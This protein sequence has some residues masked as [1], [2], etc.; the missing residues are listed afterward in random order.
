[1]WLLKAPSGQVG[2]VL[3][4]SLSVQVGSSG[5]REVHQLSFPASPLSLATAAPLGRSCVS[6]S[7]AE[8]CGPACGPPA[9]RGFTPVPCG[10]E[11][12]PGWKGFTVYCVKSGCQRRSLL[13]RSV[14]K[15]F[16]SASGGSLSP[17][18]A[19]MAAPP[20]RVPGNAR[21]GNAHLLPPRL[22]IGPPGAPPR[23]PPFLSPIGR[24]VKAPG[25]DWRRRTRRV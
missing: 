17:R 4:L 14:W 18:G 15:R 6:L 5:K 19:S 16:C 20:A 25:A 24:P 23:A 1:M 22:L 7:A 12:S 3:A 11:A 21:P 13:A 9:S 10:R 2:H 8:H